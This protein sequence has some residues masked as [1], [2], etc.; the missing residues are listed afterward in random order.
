MLLCCFD[1]KTHFQDLILSVL[2]VFSYNIPLVFIC[3]FL[4]NRGFNVVTVV[5]SYSSVSSP[6][7]SRVWCGNKCTHNLC[8]LSP[9][10][11]LSGSLC[12]CVSSRCLSNLLARSLFVSFL[13]HIFYQSYLHAFLFFVL[14]LGTDVCAFSLFLCRSRLLSRLPA[15]F[16]SVILTFCNTRPSLCQENRRAARETTVSNIKES[17]DN[18]GHGSS[19][20]T[21]GHK[22]DVPF[23]RDSLAQG[24]QTNDSQA[25]RLHWKDIDVCECVCV[26]VRARACMFLCVCVLGWWWCKNI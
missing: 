17:E 16:A 8:L 13:L 12:C 25:G 9:P 23:D 2:F 20:S 4:F 14:F 15:W 18:H 1:C 19:R 3:V 5:L 21:G 24:G 7:W 22:P 10:P 26:C 11:S 6:S